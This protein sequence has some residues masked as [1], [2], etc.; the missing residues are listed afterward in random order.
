MFYNFDV[1]SDDEIKQ[2]YNELN[3]V[4]CLISWDMKQQAD[5]FDYNLKN[6][7]QKRCDELEDELISRGI[8]VD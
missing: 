5:D 4:L 2:E 8:F 7:Y 6:N 1:M 3:E